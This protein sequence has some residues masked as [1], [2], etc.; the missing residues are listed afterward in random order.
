MASDELRFEWRAIDHPG[1][2]T[3]PHCRQ[4]VPLP[5][6]EPWIVV[7][8]VAAPPEC[9]ESLLCPACAKRIHLHPSS[10][11]PIDDEDDDIFE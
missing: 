6:T 11:A 7:G 9:L 8:G 3:C 2:V 4:V 1:S 10:D 5:K